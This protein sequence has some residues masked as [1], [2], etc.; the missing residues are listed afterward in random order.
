MKKYFVIFL[1]LLD[2]GFA[3]SLQSITLADTPLA[4]DLAISELKVTGDE[5]V[6]LRNTTNTSLQ[7]NDFW[8]QYFNDFD[9]ART[10]SANSFQLP[11]V[12]LKPEQE[13]LLSAGTAAAC[14][15]VWVSKLAVGLKDSAGMLQ[16]LSLNQNGGIVGYKPQDQVSWSSKTTDNVDIKGVSGSAAKQIYY[17]ADSGWEADDVPPGCTAT[18]AAVSPSTGTPEALTQNDTSPPSVLLSDTG[19]TAADSLPSA[20]T[21][22]IAPQVSEILPNPALPKTDANDEYIELYNPNNQ[23]FDLSNFKLQTA[24]GSSYVFPDG[25][26]TLEPYQFKAFFSSSTNLSLPNSS[27]QVKL[28]SPGGELLEISDTY[29]D[30]PEDSSWVLA[31]GLWQWTSV[32]TPDARNIITAGG[33]SVLGDAPAPPALKKTQTY[34]SLSISELLPNPK[35]PQTDAKDEFIEIY[36]PNTQPVNLSGYTLVSGSKDNHKYTI[37][38]GSIGPKAYKA[39]YAP[40]THL[41]LSNSDGRAKILSPG[42]SQIDATADYAKAPDGQSWIYA[43]GKWQWTT[44]PTPGKANTYTAPSAAASSTGSSSRF[45][46]VTSKSAGPGGE[47]AKPASVHPLI[48]AGIGSA[49][50][51][52]ACYE[53]R[54]DVANLIYRLRRNRSL[55]RAAGQAVETT[56]SFR[57]PF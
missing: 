27:G 14:G 25:R 26:S 36:N 38:S 45:G 21:G 10:T 24:A 34:A 1:M 7:L 47:T 19:E 35:T 37:K 11:S 55:G 22:L 13:I 50:L 30:A 3:W 28:L 32:L 23:T 9:L 5:F 41:T 16:I 42:G 12:W 49:V 54:H 4:K 53:Y 46:G 52:Y 17:L 8:L 56:G 33:P 44:V 15:Q 20:D 57:A 40:E 31:D 51:L 6:V 18:T 48:L 43:G 39:F 2:G 29:A